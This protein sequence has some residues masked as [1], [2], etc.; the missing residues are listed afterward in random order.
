MPVWKYKITDLPV[1]NGDNHPVTEALF[2]NRGYTNQALRDLFLTPN[3]DRDS[4][5]PFLFSQM[6]KIVE[7]IG[8]AKESGESIGIFGDFDADGVTSSVIIRETLTAL[9]VPVYFYL[10]E[11]ISEGHGFNMKAIDFFDSKGVKLI[12][13]LDCG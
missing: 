3:F 4:H 2:I 13:T 5:D 8:R 7:R 1:G 11:K 12:M 6:E 10:P 9:G